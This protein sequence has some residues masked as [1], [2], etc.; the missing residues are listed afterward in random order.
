VTEQYDTTS[1]SFLRKVGQSPIVIIR[2]D[3]PWD[4]WQHESRYEV[5]QWPDHLFSLR[6]PVLTNLEQDLRSAFGMSEGTK[7]IATNW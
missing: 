3:I 7:T 1:V 5:V 4:W 2:N 6:H